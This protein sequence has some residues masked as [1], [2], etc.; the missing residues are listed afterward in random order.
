MG[1]KSE[2]KNQRKREASNKNSNKTKRFIQKPQTVSQFK[3]SIKV[4]AHD[5]KNKQKRVEVHAQRKIIQNQLK[6]KQ[7][8]QRQ[9]LPQ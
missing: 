5:I 3:D 1:K 4:Q 2:K 6:M 7:R 8:K 9:K